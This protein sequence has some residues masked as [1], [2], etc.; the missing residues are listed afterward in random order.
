MPMWRQTED[1][2]QLADARSHDFGVNAPHVAEP[3]HVLE[4]R[5][6]AVVVATTKDGPDFG[7]RSIMDRGGNRAAIWTKDIRYAA[8]QRSL[9]GPIFAEEYDYFSRSNFD[10]AV[11]QRM[12]R[13]TA[14]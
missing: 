12:N 4:G 3:H 7:A 14:T 1:I 5:F 11:Y 9:A 10:A 2:E 13:P 6:V 8:N